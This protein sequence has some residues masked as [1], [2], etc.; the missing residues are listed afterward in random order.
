MKSIQKWTLREKN[1]PLILRADYQVPYGDIV[2]FLDD[3]RAEGVVKVQA[4]TKQT[5]RSK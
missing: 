4:L 1:E 2:G 3:L 5:A